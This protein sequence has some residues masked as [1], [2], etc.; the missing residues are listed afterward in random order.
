ML[1]EVQVHPGE[2]PVVLIRRLVDWRKVFGTRC[3]PYDDSAPVSWMHSDALLL[4]LVGVT[5]TEFLLFALGAVPCTLLTPLLT[6]IF[7]SSLSA[8]EEG[9]EYGGNNIEEEDRLCERG[10]GL[11]LSVFAFRLS[12]KAA[13]M[14]VT[15]VGELIIHCFPPLP[16]SPCITVWCKMRTPSSMRKM[17]PGQISSLDALRNGTPFR[18]PLMD[19]AVGVGGSGWVCN[20]SMR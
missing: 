14:Q 18:R 2:G 9:L 12:E 3:P 7:I 10:R 5:H 4:V 17:K 19:A 1:Q 15:L 11:L 13:E 16:T 8:S 20:C 6:V